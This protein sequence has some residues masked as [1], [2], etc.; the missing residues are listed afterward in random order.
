ML[1]AQLAQPG[2]TNHTMV[3]LPRSEA[4]VAAAPVGA[5]KV[6][7]GAIGADPVEIGWLAEARTAAGLEGSERPTTR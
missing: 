5:V 4:M 6:P 1:A 7:F 2:A 3:G